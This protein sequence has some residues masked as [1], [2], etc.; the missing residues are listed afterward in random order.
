MGKRTSA[1][2]DS[3]ICRLSLELGSYVKARRG[4][5]AVHEKASD[6]TSSGGVYAGTPYLFLDDVPVEKSKKPNEFIVC[7][8]D[9]SIKRCLLS[10]EHE[11]PCA[12]LR[13][14]PR[15]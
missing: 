7:L 8:H 6:D 13:K 1:S 11:K 10:I 3:I 9:R 5:G 15:R 2:C 12:E 14:R 4:K